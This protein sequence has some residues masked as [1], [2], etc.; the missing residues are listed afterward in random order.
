ATIEEL[1]QM[2]NGTGF[3]ALGRQPKLGLKWAREYQRYDTSKA[4]MFLGFTPQVALRDGVAALAAA[5]PDLPDGT[6]RLSHQA[7][8]VGQLYDWQLDFSVLD[9]Y[10]DHSDFLNW[11]YWD[12]KATNQRKSCENLMEKLLAFI[13][14]KRGRILDVACGKGATTRHLLKY[15]KPENVTGINV[16]EKQLEICRKNARGCTFL[17][18]DATKLKFGDNSFDNIICVE[19]AGHFDTRDEFLR[20]AHRVL[21]PGGRLVLSDAVFSTRSWLPHRQ[22]ALR[23]ANYIRDTGEYRKVCLQAGFAEVVTMDATE[24]SWG[25]FSENVRAYLKDSL[26]GG[27][28]DERTYAMV[29]SQLDR[30][31]STFSFYVIASCLKR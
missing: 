22:R 10:Y 26:F 14:K 1:T 21:K 27:T 23:W 7:A 12:A 9:D 15:Y 4:Q 20:E 8:L 18:M 2:I 28:M 3:G 6:S 11:G 24:E 31:A 19:A 17:L 5:G 25:G 13:P 16:T 30:M 29:T